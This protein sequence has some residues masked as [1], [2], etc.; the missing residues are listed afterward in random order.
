MLLLDLP[1]C[2]VMAVTVLII[3]YA[4]GVHMSLRAARQLQQDNIDCAV[5][6]LRWLAPLPMVDVLEHASKFTRV[7]IVDETRRTGGVAEGIISEL[8]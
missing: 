1:N 6:D 2:G 3:T 8:I 7:L 4:N 5:L